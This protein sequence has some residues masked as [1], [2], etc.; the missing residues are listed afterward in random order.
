ME[1]YKIIYSLRV[2][3]ALVEKG[4]FPVQTMPNPKNVKYNC[5]V[6]KNSEKLEALATQLMEG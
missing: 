2:M 6:F 1:E 4:F 3:R 5:W